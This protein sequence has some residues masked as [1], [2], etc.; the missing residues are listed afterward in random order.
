MKRFGVIVDGYSTGAG[1]APEFLKYSIFCIHVQSQKIIPKVYA[2]TYVPEHYYAQHF[3]NE[4]FSVLIT[5]LRSYNPEFVIA[6]AECGIELADQL[7]AKLGLPGNDIALSVHRRNKHLMRE[8]IKAKGLQT[9]PSMRVETL[10]EVLSWASIQNTWPLIVKPLSSAGGEGVK[11][12][13]TLEDVSIGFLDIMATKINMLGFK[14]QYV[15]IQHYIEGEEYVVNTAS[16]AGKHKFCELWTYTRYVLAGG[17]KIYDTAKIIDIETK[18]HEEVISYALAVVEA[19][20]IKYGAAHVEVIKNEQGCFLVE[21]GARLMGANLPFSLLYQCITTSQVSYT[22]MAYANPQE[23]REKIEASYQVVQP[24]IA[25]FM[26]STT[27]GTIKAINFLNEIKSV[28]SFYDIKL[29]VHIGDTLQITIDYQTSP[30][31]IYLTHKD[32]EIIEQD[33]LYIRELEQRM[34][35]LA[36]QA[37]KS[38]LQT[39]DG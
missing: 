33:R 19:L 9:I 8:E 26:V 36:S 17:R 5:E 35:Q 23:F 28:Q 14:N 25:L 13:H 15:L 32:P 29:A 7:S 30:G 11:I 38:T 1:Y 16:L 22:L 10:D 18:D 2:H 21:M 4:D 39:V 27:T 12:C 6:G 37:T 31:M 20:G 24:L 3:L 34:F